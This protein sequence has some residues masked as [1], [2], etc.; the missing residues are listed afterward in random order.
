RVLAFPLTMLLTC[1]LLSQC[2]T[3]T[4]AASQPV[5]PTAYLPTYP[6]APQEGFAPAPAPSLG[7]PSN[8]GNGAPSIRAVSYI[9][10]NPDTGHVISA[11]NAA[12]PRPVASTQKILTALCVLDDGNLD[13]PVRITSSDI[14]VEPSKLG[15]R[16]GE[17]YTR[18]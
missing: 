15:V 14:M 13:K 16:P 8:M 3:D 5:S 10:L 9:L 2:T 11:R 12:P 7:G 6:V 18:R 4:P 1:A 17:V